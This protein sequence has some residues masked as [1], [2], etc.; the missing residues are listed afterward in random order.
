[1]LRC[2]GLVLALVGCAADEPER[3][4][5]TIDRME[6]EPTMV[7]TP[8]QADVCELA[9]RLPADDICSLACD[10]PAL[11]ARLLADG[12]DPGACYQLYCSLPDE[13]YVLVGVCL[14]Q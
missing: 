3:G 12:S 14:P 7:A 5:I 8:D 6:D 1:M 2:V 4:P 9:A 10:P 13:R 11:A